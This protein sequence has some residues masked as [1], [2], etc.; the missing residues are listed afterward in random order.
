ML[1]DQEELEQA[2]VR[3]VS[4]TEAVEL[5]GRL[6]RNGEKLGEV[7]VLESRHR[8]GENKL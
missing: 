5:L 3:S 7:S 6:C 4:M 8:R 1:F 2:Y